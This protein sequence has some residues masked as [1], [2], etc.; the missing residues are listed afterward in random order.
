[1]LFT[2]NVAK[3][4]SLLSISEGQ[5]HFQRKSIIVIYSKSLKEFHNK[6]IV[7]SYKSSVL[8]RS[9]K[10]SLKTIEI[11]LLSENLGIREGNH[12]EK[13]SHRRVGAIAI[14]HNDT[15]LGN[16][17]IHWEIIESCFLLFIQTPIIDLKKENEETL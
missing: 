11:N 3:I 2:S 13:K 1:M 16:S 4:K 9:K 8:I 7:F 12:F 14:I 15:L 10:L 5:L 17:N 6:K